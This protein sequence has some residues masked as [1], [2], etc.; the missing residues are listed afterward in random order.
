MNQSKHY[1]A[2]L[3][4]RFETKMVIIN[5]LS[6]TFGTK[7]V[8][9]K[10]II[11][12]ASL[13]LLATQVFSQ[14]K[15][16]ACSGVKSK[17]NL[18]KSGSLSP[19]QIA[20][21]E[22]YD[23]H[24]YA[25][26]IAMTNQNT[27]VA[28]TGE[29]H[30]T[31]RENLDTVWFELFNTMTITEIRLNGTPTTFVRQGSAVKVPVNLTTGTNF[32]IA[33]DYNGTPPTAAT[34]P[35]GGSG[36]S[37]DVSPSWGNRVTWSLSEP[38]SAY[39]WWPCKQSL[40]DK[41]D[42]VSVKVTV[43]SACKAG[44]NGV[45]E[46]TV[47]LGNGT[48]R[49]EW[50]HRHPIDYYLI[51]VAV[52]EYVEYNVYANP[53]GAANPVLI[54]NFIYNNPQ[55]L[56]NFQADIDETVDFMEYF[57]EIYGLYPYA[58]EKYGHCMAPFS[59]GMEHQTM[60]TQGFFEKTLTAHELAH[61]WWGNKVTCASWSDIWVN[62]GFASYS[63]YL[64]L[65]EMYAQQNVQ[66]MSDRHDNIM[67]QPGGSVWVADSL[68]EGAIFSGRLVY[69]KGA[70]IVHTMRFIADNDT[71][72]FNALRNFQ[73]EF[74]DSVAIGL[75]VKA[76]LEEATGKSYTAAF[77]QWYFGEG[78]PTYSIDWNKNTTDLFIR[79]KH[80]TSVPNITPTFTNPLEVK[81]SRSGQTDTIIRFDITSNS[82]EFFVQ[83]I[84][85]VNAVLLAD[86]NNWII[87]KNGPIVYD[88]NL[89]V[90][91]SKNTLEPLV[92][93]YP[94]PSNG[95]VTIEVNEGGKY[96]VKVIDAHG[97]FMF[98]KDFEKTTQL[99]LS[100]TPKGMYLFQ[101]ENES[102]S[103]ITRRIVAN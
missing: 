56:P 68:N 92:S 58:N 38:F 42:S 12:L 96:R 64:M 73:T 39:E 65:D 50:K 45:L 44:S 10:K 37:N 55:T 1:I 28:G 88:P 93:I 103:R 71:Q 20:Q 26:D 17:T 74:A 41:A 5:F 59:G 34:N 3:L 79:I 61:Q 51:S 95:P 90:G 76:K 21:T 75:D 23:V 29:I 22:R 49:Y 80:T 4:L 89:V 11:T 85:N 16:H 13:L 54:Q 33:T 67:S 101:I 60:T 53:V 8:R 9:M 63:E 81:F 99:D 27:S 6:A 24:F 91:L 52:A 31:A 77:E 97:K 18:S 94:N 7:L 86:P 48:T 84:G 102:G 30:G 66:D 98:Q 14:S 19:A 15:T 100:K 43:P 83:N 72:F 69:D 35:L 40:R 87:N 32:V 2:P 57:S 36:M 47:D 46:N 70:A 78:Y 82:D 62:E 25:L